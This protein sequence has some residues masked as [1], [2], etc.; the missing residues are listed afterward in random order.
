M[1]SKAARDELAEVRGV[2]WCKACLVLLRGRNFILRAMRNLWVVLSR[3]C[4]A[5]IILSLAWRMGEMRA[6]HTIQ[7]TT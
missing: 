5:H 4:S 1:G 3:A 2:R 6:K 7:K